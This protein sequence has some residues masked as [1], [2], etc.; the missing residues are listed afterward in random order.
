MKLSL[1]QK[2]VWWVANKCGLFVI[3][4]KTILSWTC[5]AGEWIQVAG[6]YDLTDVRRS[7]YYDGLAVSLNNCCQDVRK[8]NN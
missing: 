7:G 1:T 5:E 6:N 8:L 3:H 2:F 4:P